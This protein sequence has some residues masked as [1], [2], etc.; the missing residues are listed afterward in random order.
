[1]ANGGERAARAALRDITQSADFDAILDQ[2]GRLNS[3]GKPLV[4]ELAEKT[5][6]PIGI[7]DESAR[8]AFDTSLATIRL[9]AET[10]LKQLGSRGANQR[11]GRS[12]YRN[13]PALF[14]QLPLIFKDK[15]GALGFVIRAEGRLLYAVVKLTAA[16]DELYLTSARWTNIERLRSQIRSGTI[17]RGGLA[18]VE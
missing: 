12:S 6:F 11:F 4:T 18:D 1:M 2:F 9:S 14:E 3:S 7:L 5:F 15:H 17:I 16:G 13:L 8:D 10:Y